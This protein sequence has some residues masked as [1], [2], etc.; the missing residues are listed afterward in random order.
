MVLKCREQNGIIDGK[1]RKDPPQ[2]NF[3]ENNI[4]LHLNFIL[5]F[6]YE[7]KNK[8]AKEI[9]TSIFPTTQIPKNSKYQL[10]LI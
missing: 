5:H 2:S 4:Q 1:K 9:V 7:Q 8:K 6:M 3:V 10:V